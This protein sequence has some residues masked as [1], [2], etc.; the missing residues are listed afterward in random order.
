[1]RVYEAHG[2][3]GEA[4]LTFGAPLASAVECNLIEEDDRPVAWHGSAL[5]FDYLPYQ[6]RTFKVRFA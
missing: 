2:A 4:M 3:R 1:M 6:I 5:S